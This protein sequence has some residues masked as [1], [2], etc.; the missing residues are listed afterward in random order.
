MPEWINV[1]LRST[2]LFLLTL[3]LVRLIG[4]RQTSRLTFF[5][6]TTGVVVGVMAAAISLNLTGN[7]ANGLIAL[8]V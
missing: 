2:G 3:L 8:A 7:L 1:L 5:D 6:L 4:K